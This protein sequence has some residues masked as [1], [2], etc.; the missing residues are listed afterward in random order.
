MDLLQATKSVFA[1]VFILTIMEPPG[2]AE[3]TNGPG[4]S[5]GRA[6]YVALGLAACVVVIVGW[7][8]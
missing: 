2:A 3:G 1:S 6:R 8:L 5:R 4:R 7:S